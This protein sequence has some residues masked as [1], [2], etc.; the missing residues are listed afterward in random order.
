MSARLKL[1]A[2]FL[3]CAAPFVLG[4]A[5]WYFEW[6]TGSRGNYGE[7]LAPRVVE[8]PPFLPSR[9]KWIL[10]SFDA[11]A[12]DAHCEQK[13]YYMRQ[14]RTALGKEQARVERLWLITDGRPPRADVL[15]S[16]EGTRVEAAAQAGAFP[17][18][19]PDHI[20]LIDPLGNL[21]LRFPREPDPSKMLRDLQ[22]LLKYSKIG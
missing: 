7:L 15:A 5:A 9:G 20:Y 17:G 6:G 22:R 13:L 21:M 3:A 4:W 16:Y 18:N 2:L 11:G 12:C 1:A 14:V 10:V 19:L 8:D